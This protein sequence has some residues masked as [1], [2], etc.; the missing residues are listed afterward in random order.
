MGLLDFYDDPAANMAL[1]AGLL[2]GGNFGTALGKGMANAQNL[3]DSKDERKRRNEYMQA[4]AE[5]LRS[6]IAKREAE[7]RQAERLRAM[8]A[9]LFTAPVSQGAYSPSVDGMGPVMP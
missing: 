9:S 3:M 5:N 8:I 7:I 1:A 4:Q 2:S 6:E